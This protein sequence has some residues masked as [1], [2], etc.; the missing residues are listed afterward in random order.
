MPITENFSIEQE[1]A[2]EFQP[3]KAGIY[4]AQLID[5]NVELNP[6]YN[7]KSVMVKNFT[8]LF[9]VLEE[10]NVGRWI[11]Y[12]FIPTT[13]YVGKKGKNKLYK[14]VEALLGS[15][16]TEDQIKKFD[17]YFVGNLTGEQILLGLNTK[18]SGE[19]TINV[20]DAV[21][22]IKAPLTPIADIDRKKMCEDYAEAQKKW[23]QG[24]VEE[25]D[26]KLPVI[27]QEDDFKLTDI[28]Y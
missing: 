5:V 15:E 10:P 26:E 11:T 17:A 8:F 14:L 13:L 21:Y 18:I 6:D 19:N 24:K 22:K 20:I 3:L 28:P 25:V 27:Q 9:A 16:L 2:K 23:K 7:D 12:R 4:Q 1:E